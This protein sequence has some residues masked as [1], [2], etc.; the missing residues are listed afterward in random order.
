[1]IPM[2]AVSS[3]SMRQLREVH[4]ANEI[5]QARSFHP[6]NCSVSLEATSHQGA[7]TAPA[8]QFFLQASSAIGEVNVPLWQVWELPAMPQAR[9]TFGGRMTNVQLPESA[10]LGISQAHALVELDEVRGV[11]LRR[12]ADEKYPTYYNGVILEADSVDLKHGDIIGFGSTDR[13]ADTPDVQAIT[14]RT[15]LS[16]MHAQRESFVKDLLGAVLGTADFDDLSALEKEI[17]KV[18]SRTYFHDDLFAQVAHYI[19]DV[20]AEK[21]AD[22]AIANQDHVRHLLPSLDVYT[23]GV[24]VSNW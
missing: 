8:A 11:V 19:T 13:N 23:G 4:V 6:A 9:L 24:N 22:L 2:I 18:V 15:D 12:L 3:S 16:A 1:M 20:Y 10:E 5:V 21:E 14:F 7:I 17:L